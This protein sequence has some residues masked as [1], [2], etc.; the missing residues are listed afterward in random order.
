MA[1]KFNKPKAA[2]KYHTSWDLG[3]VITHC[4]SCHEPTHEDEELCTS[5]LKATEKLNTELHKMIK[6]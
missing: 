5:C 4:Q 2:S 1:F 6:D 3:K